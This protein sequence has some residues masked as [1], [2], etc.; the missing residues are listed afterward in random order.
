MQVFDCTTWKLVLPLLSQSFQRQNKA[1][2]DVPS[3]HRLL[4]FPHLKIPPLLCIQI[5]VIAL[6]GNCAVF[7]W[8]NCHCLLLLECKHI[9]SLCNEITQMKEF[10]D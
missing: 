3:Q 7:G 2:Y 1:F 10:A 9:V 8:E 6:F 5:T 4:L